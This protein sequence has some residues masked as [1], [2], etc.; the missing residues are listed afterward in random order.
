[1]KQMA[2]KIISSSKFQLKYL[3]FRIQEL[4]RLLPE[5]DFD[6]ETLPPIDHE[7]VNLEE[8]LEKSGFTKEQF[9][10]D[11]IDKL[12]FFRENGYVVLESILDKEK[13]DTCWGEIENLIENPKGG[14][15]KGI[16]HEY[17]QQMDTNV[18][19]IPLE[20]RRGIG[21][22]FNNTFEFSEVTRE[23]S[24]DIQLT[25]FLK[26]VLDENPAIFQSLIFKYS[27]QQDAHQDFPWV[28]TKIPSHLAAAWIPLEDVHP[29]S[30]PLFYYPKSHRIKKFNFGNTGIL[31][32]RGISFYRDIHFA[33]YLSRYLEKENY[34]KEILLIKK[35]DVLI[36]HGALVHGG[37]K[38]K[39]LN[40]TR[41]SLVVHYSSVIGYPKHRS[42]SNENTI[43]EGLN[44]MKIHFSKKDYKFK[45]ILKS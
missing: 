37:D 27:S 1:M 13:L 28:T 34:K 39:D 5:E 3:K 42:E 35:G 31:Y 6:G 43:S 44:G 2:K 16:A 8:L 14:V 22:R 45:N 33:S 10:F 15:I 24:S 38:I 36:W 41:K 26:L 32:K 40:K 9:S 12:I 11:I 21:T 18:D 30:G 25:N 4:L 17:N 20:K 23:V 7:N 19:E 29:D